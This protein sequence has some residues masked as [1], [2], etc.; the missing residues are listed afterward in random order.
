MANIV[1][2]GIVFSPTLNIPGPLITV[3]VTDHNGI[4]GVPVNPKDVDSSLLAMLSDSRQE[5][6]PA[7]PD[8]PSANGTQR[9]ERPEAPGGP[10]ITQDFTG[11]D[12]A[13]AQRMAKEA[14]DTGYTGP[15]SAKTPTG[16]QYPVPLRNPSLQQIQNEDSDSDQGANAHTSFHSMHFPDPPMTARIPQQGESSHSS[17][18]SPN[19][20]SSASSTSTLTNGAR[21]SSSTGGASTFFNKKSSIINLNDINISFSPLMGGTSPEFNRGGFGAHNAFVPSNLTSSMS[22]GQIPPPSAATTPITPTMNTSQSGPVG[23][24]AVPG[25]SIPSTKYSELQSAGSPTTPRSASL[26][27]VTSAGSGASDGSAGGSTG[28]SFGRRLLRRQSGAFLVRAGL[29]DDKSSRAKVPEGAPSPKGFVPGGAVQG[30]GV[31]G[32]GRNGGFGRKE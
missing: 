23:N 8:L 4:F 9:P 22:A 5:S 19:T 32:A 18:R 27:S 6:R 13:T 15:P 7:V 11:A 25:S 2:V 16:Q 21:D 14:Y 26:Q 29:I 24:S 3:F 17:P 12:Y 31:E 28:S 10:S 1:T 20:M 30:L